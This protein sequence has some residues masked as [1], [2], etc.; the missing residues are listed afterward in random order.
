MPNPSKILGHTWNKDDDTPELLAKPFPSEHPVTKCT[1]LSYL[2]T[3]YD[4]LGIISPTMAEGKHIYREA[5]DE[6]KGWNAEVSP[7]L[8]NEWLRWMKQ[9]RDVKVPRS[10]GSFVREIG[11][12]HL[13]LFA[14]ASILACCAAVVAGVE[15]EAGVTKGLLTSKSRISKRSISIA[16][17]EL[18]SGHMA[19][20]MAKNLS[21][22]LQRWPIQT[23]NIWMDSMVALYW[24]TNPG[25]EWKVFVSNR[26]KNIAETA[27]PVNITWKN[28][29]SE[30]SLADVG[31]RGATI[32]EMERGNWFA[33]PDWLLD[34]RRWPEQ[35]RLNCTKETDEESNVTQEAVLRT[36]ER[37]FDEWDAL[38]E[39]QQHGCYGLSVTAK[40]G[41]SQRR[42]QVY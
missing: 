41:A 1:I 17:L 36:V 11:A 30:L 23:I 19:V 37:M 34:K 27:G 4:P 39:M 9:L 21:T 14:D 24:I 6:K 31:S 22:A 28:C 12:V 18:V 40:R 15:H 38:L 32:V 33:G 10:I 3:V 8:K 7:R 2:G 42:C 5:R 20:N 16:R 25:R 29:P 35:P 13:H 26:V